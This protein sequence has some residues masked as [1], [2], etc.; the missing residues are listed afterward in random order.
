MAFRAQESKIKARPELVTR[1]QD[2]MITVEM[3]IKGNF[4]DILREEM[5]K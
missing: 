4:R 2:R 3:E 5:T 1:V